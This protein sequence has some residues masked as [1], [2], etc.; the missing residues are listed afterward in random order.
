MPTE[1]SEAK[2]NRLRRLWDDLTMSVQDMAEALG[3]S[4]LAIS[5]QWLTGAIAEARMIA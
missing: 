5:Q 2:N 4:P 1:W 3:V